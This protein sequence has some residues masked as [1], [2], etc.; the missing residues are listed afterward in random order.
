MQLV[1]VAYY[2]FD[3]II[4]LKRAADTPEVTEPYGTQDWPEDIHVMENA[5]DPVVP[6]PLSRPFQPSH[7]GG[8]RATYQM[9]SMALG[10]NYC[11]PSAELF[12]DSHAWTYWENVGPPLRLRCKGPTTYTYN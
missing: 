2:C 9:V 1:M 3:N 10:A 11:S 4:W 12:P 8:A 7:D 6:K 5:E